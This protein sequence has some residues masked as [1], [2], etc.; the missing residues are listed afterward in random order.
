MSTEPV[1]IVCNARSGSTLLRYLLD[2]HPE[3]ACPAENPLP[4]TCGVVMSVHAILN[5]VEF[6]NG[7]EPAVMTDR[8]GPS[9]TTAHRIITELMSE[10]LH[11]RGKTIWC[12]KSLFAIPYID[13]ITSVFPNARY[14]CLH[15]HGMDVIGSALEAC[16][17]GYDL[18]GLTPYIKKHNDNFVRG[19]AEYWIRRT[20]EIIDFEESGIVR[21]HRVQYENLVRDTEGTVADIL[22]FLG[23]DNDRKIVREMV[24]NAFE[25]DHDPGAADR[26]ITYT[27]AIEPGSVE[28]G[29]AV[30]AALLESA[31]RAD[32]NALLAALG[33]PVVT[34]DWNV[35]SELAAEADRSLLSAAD[36]GEC[37]D[38]LVRDLLAPR[39]AAYQG[40]VTACVELRAT[41]GDGGQRRWILDSRSRTIKP[42]SSAVQ[43]AP[44]VVT[45][46]AEVLRDLLI[47]GLPLEAAMRL[48][49]MNVTGTGGNGLD[50]AVSRLVT[51]LFSG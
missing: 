9:A 1:F 14:L 28:R 8:M 48:R 22:E 7:A 41:H 15:R 16:R 50:R 2:A 24:E 11:R 37:A 13:F 31:P 26:K 12:D 20:R 17:W 51:A 10:Y 35:S 40:P 19:L 47:G 5:G 6:P 46:R 4:Q 23:L 49:M 18:Y 38:G 27:S 25:N 29:R 43:P 36:V 45:A 32:M 33:Y 21:T 34:D 44:V 3:I 42:G 39:L 30:P